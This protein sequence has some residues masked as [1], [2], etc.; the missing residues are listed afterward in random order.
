MNIVHIKFF[1]KFDCRNWSELF[2]FAFSTTASCS[3]FHT[4]DYEFTSFN[5][6]LFRHEQLSRGVKCESKTIFFVD[7]H[8]TLQALDWNWGS[9]HKNQ[10]VVVKYLSHILMLFVLKSLLK[11][12]RRTRN[13]FYFRSKRLNFGGAS[14][15]W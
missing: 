8:L 1:W 2:F 12:A 5:E 9:R 11:S 15:R 4:T 3:L 13:C 14:A 7:D 10:F 6:L